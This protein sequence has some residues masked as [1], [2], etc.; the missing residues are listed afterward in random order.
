MEDAQGGA[1]DIVSWKVGSGT[2]GG[3]TWLRVNFR[4]KSIVPLMT[5]PVGFMWQFLIGIWALVP[6][7]AAVDGG[8]SSGAE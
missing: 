4:D 2:D 6:G 7:A 8:G 5:P 1:V 3:P